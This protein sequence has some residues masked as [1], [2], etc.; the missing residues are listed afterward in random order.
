MEKT[1]EKYKTYVAILNKE[2]KM[3]MGC[4]EPIALAYCSALA[5]SVLEEMPQK[6][7]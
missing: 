6:I 3:A 1:S 2:L 4:T 7:H 5:R